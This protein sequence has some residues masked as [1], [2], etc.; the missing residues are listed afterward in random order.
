MKALALA[1]LLGLTVVARPA[2]AHDAYDDSQ[3]NPLRIVAYMVHPVGWALEWMVA[4]PIHFL[5]SDPELERIFG[6][7]AHE[8]PFGDYE[9]YRQDLDLDNAGSDDH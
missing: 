9:P 8:S 3:S 2:L 4:R 1:L 7:E 5:V 6:H